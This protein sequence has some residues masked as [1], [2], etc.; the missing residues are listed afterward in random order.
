MKRLLDATRRSYNETLAAL[1]KRF[2]PESKREL[3]AAEFQTRRKGKTESWADFAEDLWRLADRAH[4]DL[5]EAAREK[6][7]LTRYLSQIAD[8]QVSWC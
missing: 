3:Y 5:E 2:E 1:K 7:F 6:L 4:A 8:Q